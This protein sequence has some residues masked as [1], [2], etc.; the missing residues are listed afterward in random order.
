MRAREPSEGDARFRCAHRSTPKAQK[1]ILFK[2]ENELFLRMAMSEFY[3]VHLRGTLSILNGSRALSSAA[4]GRETPQAEMRGCY[5]HWRWWTE[6]NDG[7]NVLGTQCIQHIQIREKNTK[8][9]RRKVHPFHWWARKNRSDMSEDHL[10]QSNKEFL[11][12]MAD[13]LYLGEFLS[14]K[15]LS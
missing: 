13:K 10:T 8:P 9:K 12:E 7:D 6:T 15:R 2:H 5:G 11:D 1:R 4:G 14:W 3:S